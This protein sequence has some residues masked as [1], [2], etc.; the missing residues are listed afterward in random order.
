MNAEFVPGWPQQAAI[1]HVTTALLA[2]FGVLQTAM[3]AVRD[4]ACGFVGAKSLPR[5]LDE[6]GML[7][8]LEKSFDSSVR[9]TSRIELPGPAFS[10]RVSD[11]IATD[12]QSGLNLHYGCRQTDKLPNVPAIA[13]PRSFAR[14]KK[15]FRANHGRD[16]H[17]HKICQ[18]E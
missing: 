12:E 5:T 11:I 2:D 1:Y 6:E 17:E 13:T 4:P 15:M 18:R 14:V 16:G 7:R 8:N 3:N 10:S 9:G